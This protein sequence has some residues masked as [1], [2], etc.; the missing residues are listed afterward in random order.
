MDILRFLDAFDESPR[1]VSTHL[2]AKDVLP[3]A[4]AAAP[5]LPA[6]HVEVSLT[7]AV[8]LDNYICIFN[9]DSGAS[10]AQLKAAPSEAVQF[11]PKVR[12]N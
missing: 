9:V 11:H 4:P 7:A 1:I 2:P 5:Y 6:F 10:V 12:R 3:S 8:S